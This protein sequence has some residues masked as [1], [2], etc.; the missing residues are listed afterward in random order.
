MHAHAASKLDLT[1]FFSPEVRKIMDGD[2]ITVVGRTDD[3]VSVNLSPPEHLLGGSMTPSM[4]HAGGQID[5]THGGLSSPPVAHTPQVTRADSAISAPAAPA[6]VRNWA[7][8][9]R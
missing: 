1:D 8:S 6:A 4:T 2:G 9:A 5:L 3:T 7:G